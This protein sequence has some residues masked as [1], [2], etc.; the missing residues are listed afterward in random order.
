[1]HL[2]FIKTS[3]L[4]VFIFHIHKI[5]IYFSKWLQWLNRCSI[6]YEDDHLKIINFGAIILLIFLALPITDPW[7]SSTVY[8]LVIMN[9]KSCTD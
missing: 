6:Y 2:N 7:D 5:Y 9:I 1:M 3:V 4:E 8:T